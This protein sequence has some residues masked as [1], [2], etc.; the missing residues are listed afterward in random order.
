M[1]T[2]KA[3]LIS[4][5]DA[6]TLDAFIDLGFQL[7]IR[8]RIGLYQTKPIPEKRDESVED[9]KERLSSPFIVQTIFNRKN[10]TG[11]IFGILYETEN[12]KSINAQMVEDGLLEKFEQAA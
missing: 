4:V 7:T 10:K 3:K 5:V 6:D 2:Y 8:Q 9:L 1:Y 11:R 12:E